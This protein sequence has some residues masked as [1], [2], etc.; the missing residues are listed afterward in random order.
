MDIDALKTAQNHNPGLLPAM[1]RARGPCPP[2]LLPNGRQKLALGPAPP[3]GCA[4]GGNARRGPSNPRNPH[5][6]R[7]A[8]T[9][10]TQMSFELAYANNV[11]ALSRPELLSGH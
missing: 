3:R 11:T 4:N 2:R 9:L 8:A 1:R 7:P 6:H 10:T 5:P